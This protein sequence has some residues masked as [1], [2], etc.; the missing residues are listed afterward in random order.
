MKVLKKILIL[1]L[2]VASIFTLAA[3]ANNQNDDNDIFQQI[4]IHKPQSSFVTLPANRR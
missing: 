4:T 3:C 2:A 1:A